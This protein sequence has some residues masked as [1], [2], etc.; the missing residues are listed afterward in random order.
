MAGGNTAKARDVPEP[1]KKP[2]PSKPKQDPEKLA[3]A[4]KELEARNLFRTAQQ[5]ER[6]GQRSAAKDF[7][8]KV[9]RNYPKTS[10]ASKAS[11][12]LKSFGE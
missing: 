4:R 11:A 6:M 2:A 3:A 12:R 7:Y 1:P 5:A 8:L 9:A 10:Y